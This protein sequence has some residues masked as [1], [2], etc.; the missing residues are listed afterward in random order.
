MVD[1]PAL[2]IGSFNPTTLGL[3]YTRVGEYLLSAQLSALQDQGKLHILSSPSITT[4]DNQLAFIES[5]EDIPYQTVE[6]GEVNVEY[7]KA[8]LKL[9]VTPNVIDGDTLKLDI[10]VNKDEADF[11]RTVLGN[12]TIITKKAETIV[13]QNDGQTIVIGGMTSAALKYGLC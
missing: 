9:E 13:I 8:V 1:L 6:D 4:Q 3:I 5:G 2:A 10:K 7:R 12:P 11:T